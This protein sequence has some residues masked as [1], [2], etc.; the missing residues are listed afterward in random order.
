[1]NYGYI[2]PP[3]LFFLVVSFSEWKGIKLP[4]P[5]LYLTLGFGTRFPLFFYKLVYY[6]LD[7]RSRS[8]FSLQTFY[9]IFAV[10][11]PPFFAVWS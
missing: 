5:S 7:T 1:M 6:L 3:P 4:G 11:P 8:F 2:L 9:F 10:S